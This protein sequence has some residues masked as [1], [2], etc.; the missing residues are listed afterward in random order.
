MGDPPDAE[1]EVVATMRD[2]AA[3]ARLVAAHFQEPEIALTFARLCDEEAA[4]VLRMAKRQPRVIGKRK[5]SI[6]S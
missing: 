5:P 4:H 6:R 3:N 2:L 1:H